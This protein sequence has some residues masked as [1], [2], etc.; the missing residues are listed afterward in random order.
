MAK[1]RG[2][3]YFFLSEEGQESLHKDLSVE[4]DLF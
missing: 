1:E 2:K 4:E 3:I